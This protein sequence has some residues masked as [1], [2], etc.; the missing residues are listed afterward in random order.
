MS[1]THAAPHERVL[2][3]DHAIELGAPKERRL[4]VHVRQVRVKQ[5]RAY[6][7]RARLNPLAV[8]FHSRLVARR[9]NRG[10]ENLSFGKR[11]RT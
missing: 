7:V 11:T 5:F 6:Q 4:K 9:D 1:P 3:T 2:L 8:H 10:Y